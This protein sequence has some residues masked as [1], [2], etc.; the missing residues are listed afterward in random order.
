MTVSKTCRVF[1]RFDRDSPVWGT[2]EASFRRPGFDTTGSR[3]VVC[4]NWY[5]AQQYATWLQRR[6]GK[7]YRLL[8][9]SEW[10][11]AARAGTQ[12]R[13]SFGDDETQLC[14]YAQ[15]ADLGS[16][17]DWGDACRSAIAAYGTVPVGSFRPNPWGL[18]DMHGNAWEWV[19]DCWTPNASEIPTNG[20]AF[21]RL[22]G[23]EEA[24]IR[25]GSFASGSHRV[26][27]ATRGPAPVA[28]HNYN[29]GFRVALPLND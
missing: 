4:V 18:F 11:Y 29:N 25:G 9:E 20:S 17:F 16:R 1:V 15:F 24:V 14:A 5:E 13:Y 27:S 22:S 6:T 23:C 8:T 7:P 2:V 26:R 19:Q 10:E 12:T 28:V 21:T 3:P